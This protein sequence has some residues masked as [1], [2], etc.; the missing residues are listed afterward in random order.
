MVPQCPYPFNDVKICS[1][2]TS[3]ECALVKGLNP[4]LEYNIEKSVPAGDPFCLHV[5]QQ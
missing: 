1:A 4:D 5:L 3:M 2:H